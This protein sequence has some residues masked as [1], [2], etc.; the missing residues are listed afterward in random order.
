VDAVCVTVPTASGREKY[1]L[2]AKV[3]EGPNEKFVTSAAA[4][5][6]GA[7]SAALGLTGGSAVSA[8]ASTILRRLDRSRILAAASCR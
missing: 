2:T 1:P 8:V 5:A 7:D 6:G 3:C 4:C